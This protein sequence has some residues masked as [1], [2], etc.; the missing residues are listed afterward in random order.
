MNGKRQPG[1]S[2]QRF[3]YRILRLVGLAYSA[4]SNDIKQTIAKDFY[5]KGLSK[6]LQVTLKSTANF[7]TSTLNQ[8]SDE[9]TRLE[10]AGVKSECVKIECAEVNIEEEMVNRIT[11]NVIEKLKSSSLNDGDEEVKFVDNRYRQKN[12][13]RS[14]FS[15]R[16]DSRG[17]SFTQRGSK[18]NVKGRLCR[19]CQSSS[20]LFRDCPVR[21]C[22]ACGSKGHDAW[23]N[24]CPNYR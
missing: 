11:E 22:Q 4:L 16:G 17:R 21:F 2:T 8:L 18:I 1:E 23:N 3:A 5:V 7:A 14:N 24:T 19:T 6:D 13:N 10:I 12:I 20:H 9:S 15:Y